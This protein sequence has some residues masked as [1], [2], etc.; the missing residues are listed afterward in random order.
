M[1]CEH[2]FIALSCFTGS[3]FLFCGTNSQSQNMSAR[4]NESGPV[5]GEFT[6]LQLGQDLQKLVRTI[7]V[8]DPSFSR[9]VQSSTGTEKRES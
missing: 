1:P 4:T 6:G 7:K 5:H 3:R 2:I 9:L 8:T